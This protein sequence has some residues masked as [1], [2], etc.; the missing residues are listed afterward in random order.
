[1]VALGVV[2]GRRRHDH[3]VCTR[4][5][6]NRIGGGG[7]LQCAVGEKILDLGIDDGGFAGIHRRY[8]LVRDV[9]GENLMM[10]G[11]EHG[12]GKADITETRNGDFHVVILLEF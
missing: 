12:I 1:M 11:K 8:P 4:I 3:I 7:Q 5:G 6:Q 2:I 10:L 9:N